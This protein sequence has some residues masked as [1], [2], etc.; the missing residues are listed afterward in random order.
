MRP[1][2]RARVAAR[3]VPARAQDAGA[4]STAADSADATARPLPLEADRVVPISTDRGTW[5]SLDVSP[6]GQ[7]VVFDFLGDLY[8]VPLEGGGTATALT[9][10][11]AFDSQPRYS[12][13]G[14][15]LLFVSD[16]DGAE[17]LWTLDLATGDTTAITEG[18]GSNWMSPEWMPGGDYVVASKGETR[19]GVQKLWLGH[20]DGGS[21]AVL[22]P[23]PDNLRTVGAAPTPDGRYVWFAQRQGSWNYNATFP[24]YQLAAYDRETGETFARSARYGSAFRPTLSPDGRWL[25]YGTRHEDQTGL[26]VRDLETGDERWLAYPVQFDDQESIADR[27]VLPGMAFT[28]D[29]EELVASYGGRIWRVPVDG[30]AP[31]EVPFRVEAQVAIGP[32]LFFDYPIEDTPTFTVRQVRDARPAPDGSGRL[33]FTALDRLYVQAG[34]EAAP[35]RLTEADAVEAQPVWS[36]DGDWLAYVTWDADGGHVWRVRADG[37]GEPVRVSRTAGT[38]QQPAW[39]PDG[40]RIVVVR[41]PAR[42]YREATGPGAFGAV[43]DLV[44]FPADEANAEAT[45]VAPAMNRHTPHFTDDGDRIYLT[46][47]GGA[48]EGG[49]LVSVRWDGTDERE[50]VKV[51]GAKRPGQ[52][53]PDA[54]QLVLMSP[55]GDRALASVHDHLYTVTVA[56]VGGDVRTV[57]VANPEAASFPARKLTTV[58]GQFP[59]WSADGE[60]VHWS[61]G[62]AVATYSLEAAREAERASRAAER[63]KAAG[64]STAADSVAAYEPSVRRI[65]VEAPRDLP[66]GT[67]ALRGGRVVT[68]SGDEVIEDGVVVVRDNRI[69]AVGAEGEVTVPDGAEEIDV[70]GH[71]VVPGFVDTHAHLRPPFGL[72]KS[73]SWAYHANLAYGVTTTRDPQTGT[74]DVLTYADLVRAGEMV[75]PRIYSTGPG[76]F[77]DYVEEGI[78][79][80]DHARDVLRQYSEYYDTKT[81]KMYMSGNRQQRQWIAIAAREQELT[82]TTE[83]GLMMGYNLTMLIDG[84]AGQEHNYPVFPL[85]EDVLTLTAE[86]G[87]AYTPTLLVTYGGP[88]A[89]NY[90][91]ATENPHDDAKLRRFTPHSVIDGATRRRGAGWFRDEEY[92]F[93]EHA[94][95]VAEIVRRGGRAG[96]GSH[97]QLQGLGYHWELWAVA[98]GGLSNHD[99]LRVA[100]LHGAEAIGLDGDLGSLEA[101]KL[102]DLVVL[103]RNPLDDLRNSNSVA[104]VMKNGRL[105][106][107]DTLDEVYPRERP[108]VQTDYQ[109]PEPAPAAGI[110]RDVGTP[111]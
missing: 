88:W 22:I 83:G 79:S 63:A 33:A 69:L 4:D 107:A 68:M 72:H 65:L 47:G 110:R 57:S 58:G 20:V 9:S 59:A 102:A 71:T 15:Q 104:L 98:S 21:G 101:G 48:G 42:A 24:Q 56:L 87:M 67:V 99:A 84:Y 27:D 54:A 3:A 89:E 90:F 55:Q 18:K 34:L 92:T 44:W 30:S 70:S 74:T 23:K 1:G 12:P 7:T 109:E 39:S 64:D 78:E 111:E 49:V 25:V 53:N 46:R 32:A 6:D 96:I 61:M 2:L 28:P 91:Y 19:L 80:L 14:S 105:Y 66:R 97:G 52:D 38:Y 5:M 95:G 93:P 86:S 11:M 76:V 35:R 82:P 41:G 40:E 103:A 51:V 29:S 73:Q 8:T 77:G 45:L 60:T 17:N 100:T 106:D 43:E 62:N 75:G 31:I 26:R 94:R 81:I 108:L 36:P 13:D 10:G 50:H 85:Y 37:R 16:R